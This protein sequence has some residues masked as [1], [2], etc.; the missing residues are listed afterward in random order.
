MQILIVDKLSNVA[1]HHRRSVTLWFCYHFVMV[2][3]CVINI[4]FFI[5]NW[6]DLRLE[7]NSATN[8]L[9]TIIGFLFAFAGI[10]IYSIFNTDI[11]SEKQKMLE[12][13][14]EYRN[15]TCINVDL[16]KFSAAINKFQLY[17]QLIFSSKKMNS[18]ILEWISIIKGTIEDISKYLNNV[19]HNGSFAF[20]EQNKNDV[21]ALSRG[22]R[23]QS[24]MFLETIS[25][26]D[27]VF[28]RNIDN[29]IKQSL[30]EEVN[31]LT[32]LF[33]T[34]FPEESG[35]VKERHIDAENSD[36]GRKLKNKLRESMVGRCICKIIYCLL[37]A[38]RSK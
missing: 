5:C 29:G 32:E 19:K 27:A 36:F 24:Q 13:Q 15:Q 25:A 30:L 22:F 4:I 8:I 14:E 28:F 21:L 37:P 7:I 38:M 23:Y 20:Y 2:S 35:V 16:M 10:N 34:L 9:L 6:G 12:L 33:S 11:E 31:D 26:D 17:S 18:Q 3:L 1:Q